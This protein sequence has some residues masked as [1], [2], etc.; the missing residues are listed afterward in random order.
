MTSIN[1][2]VSETLATIE[3]S[4]TT[5]VVNVQN[6]KIVLNKYPAGYADLEVTQGMNLKMVSSKKLQS[7][8]KQENMDELATAVSDKLDGL[9]KQQTDIG[10]DQS[11]VNK[12]TNVK[13]AM[14]NS[15]KSSTTLKNAQKAATESVNVNNQEIFIDFA[16]MSPDAITALSKQGAGGK[17]YIKLDQNLLND[18][19][20]EAS[21]SAVVEAISKDKAIAKAETELKEELVAKQKGLGDLTSDAV[22]VV[23][24]AVEVVGDVGGKV[25]DTAGELGGKAI[26]TTGS[27]LKTWIWIIGAVIIAIIIGFVFFSKSLFSNPD[28]MKALGSMTPMGK[29]GSM[30]GAARASAP[31]PASAFGFA[32][33]M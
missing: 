33:Y 21:L 17:S 15:I 7:V 12:I 23:G 24:Q 26:E 5:S 11:I 18:V 2:K 19:R 29:A 10:A 16:E 9:I 3:Q 25:V 20:I 6:Q 28:A 13:K 1:S 8:I 30:L 27:V 4:D 22:K 31:S 14:I 32:K